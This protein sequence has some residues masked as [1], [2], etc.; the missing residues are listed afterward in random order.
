[1]DIVSFIIGFV[2]GA[3]IALAVYILVVRSIQKGKRN[4]ILQKAEV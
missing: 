3:I 4:E 2:A 1:M